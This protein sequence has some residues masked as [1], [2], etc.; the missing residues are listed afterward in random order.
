MG[1][2]NQKS[3]LAY[4]KIAIVVSNAWLEILALKLSIEAR[5]NRAIGVIRLEMGVGFFHCYLIASRGRKMSSK[6]SV[7]ALIVIKAMTWSEC[8]RSDFAPTQCYS[9]HSFEAKQCLAI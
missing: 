3:K 4:T 6:S 9:N 7:L 1:G 2:S 8:Y 5:K